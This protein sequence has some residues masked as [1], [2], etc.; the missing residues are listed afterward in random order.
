MNQYPKGSK[1]ICVIPVNG[2][3]ELKCLNKFRELYTSRADI[4]SEY[5]QGDLIS[6]TKVFIDCCN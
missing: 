5:F 3:P 4:G 2:D 6:M 1:V